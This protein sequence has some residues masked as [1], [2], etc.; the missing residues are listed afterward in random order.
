M[1]IPTEQQFAEAERYALSKM[2]TAIPARKLGTPGYTEWDKDTQKCRITPNGCNAS[3]TNPF[4]RISY[5]SSGYFI[6]YKNAESNKNLVDFWKY[7]DTDHLVMKKV[8][9]EPDK[10]VCARANSML[11]RW[12][13]FPDLRTAKGD[14]ADYG[15]KGY[16][17][18]PG[19]EYK[20]TNG[21]E[22]CKIGADYC[23]FKGLSYDSTENKETC[24]VPPGQKFA[25]FLTG[26]TLV[27]GLNSL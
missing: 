9:A 8:S 23:K 22:T 2:C 26:T 17:I 21:V 4:S 27:R 13:E 18:G 16:A 3:S 25:E 24:Y 12:C 1:S 5:N 15:G 6:D 20:V 19:F 7:F 10:L 11:K 14:L